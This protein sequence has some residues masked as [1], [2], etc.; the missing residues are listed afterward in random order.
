[1]NLPLAL[2]FNRINGFGTMV[3][4]TLTLLVYRTVE[5]IFAYRA[6]HG[7]PLAFWLNRRHE[8]AGRHAWGF[9]LI[10]IGH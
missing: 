8:I 5:V 3:A 2:G 4:P 6:D 9:I 1:M 7:S 10:I